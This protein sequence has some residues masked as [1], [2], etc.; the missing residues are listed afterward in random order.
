[1]DPVCGELSENGPIERNS[2]PFAP[3]LAANDAQWVLC[4]SVVQCVSVLQCVAVCGNVLQRVAVCRSVLQCVAACCSVLQCVASREHHPFRAKFGR[5]RRAISSGDN[6]IFKKKWGLVAVFKYSNILTSQRYTPY[7]IWIHRS[8]YVYIQIFAQGLTAFEYIDLYIYIH[9]QILSQV[10][11][12]WLTAFKYI[13]LYIYIF[14][15]S[16]IQMFKYSNILTSQR[17]PAYNI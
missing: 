4:C 14:K 1:M 11:A 7:S 8:I 2:S 9:I 10:S 17:S 16:D 3:N 6:M 15:Y 12:P 5:K 13:H